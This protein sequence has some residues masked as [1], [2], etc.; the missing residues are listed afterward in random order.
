MTN[1]HLVV[2][3]DRLRVDVASLVSRV[4]GNLLEGGPRLAHV[5]RA[6]IGKDSIFYHLP[7]TLVQNITDDAFVV[8]GLI[9]GCSIRAIG[10]LANIPA[11]A[12]PS[13]RGYLGFVIF[14]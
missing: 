1:D 12:L 4:L 13:T 6:G 2:G 7:A 8:L 14:G 5:A 9:D 11:A 10:W 3:L